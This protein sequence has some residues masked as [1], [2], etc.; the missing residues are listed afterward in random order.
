MPA[1]GDAHVDILVGGEACKE[2]P[3]DDGK[4]Y[5]EMDLQHA[6]SYDEEYVDDTPHGVEKS[7]WPV[8][9]FQVSCRN[10]S[11]HQAYWAELH[12]DGSYV[13]Q[14]L[15]EP[16]KTV[17]FQGFPRQGKVD[18][19]LMALPRNQRATD[20]DEVVGT[21]RLSSTGSVTVQFKPAAFTHTQEQYVPGK[22][23]DFRQAN[24]IEANKANKQRLAEGSKDNMTGTARQGRTIGASDDSMATA[25]H[26]RVNIWDKG[27]VREALTVHYRQRH[28][29]LNLGVWREKEAVASE[30]A[31]NA[32]LVKTKEALG[33]DWLPHAAEV[34]AAA[35]A[36]QLYQLPQPAACRT[37]TG[38]TGASILKFSRGDTPSLAVG[39]GAHARRTEQAQLEARLL[40]GQAAA[41]VT[42][43]SG[44]SSSGAGASSSGS[45]SGGGGGGSEEELWPVVV[46]GV[47]SVFSAAAL[48]LFGTEDLWFLLRLV[49][50]HDAAACPERY[51]GACAPLHQRPRTAAL[52]SSDA[53]PTL[54][55]RSACAPLTLRLRSAHAPLT[56]NPRSCR[57]LLL[58]QTGS[59]TAWASSR[60]PS[61]RTRRC[62]RSP[63][64]RAPTSCCAARPTAACRTPSAPPPSSASPRTSPRT[65]WRVCPHP[66]PPPPAAA[67]AA[68]PTGAN[69]RT[70]PCWTGRPP[71]RCAAPAPT[72]TAAGPCCATRA[73]GRATRSARASRPST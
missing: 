23:T 35:A 3:H 16:G 43:T 21:S 47:N 2:Y 62:S 68:A 73:R 64:R 34:V 63:T 55:L 36:Y 67:A 39:G 20:G 49:A 45:S 12:L 65:C 10:L 15:L 37:P 61:T 59:R 48:A 27:A 56:L 14:R 32:L 40:G 57:L 28:V 50:K 18:E 24:K 46:E 58:S 66:P 42:G 13:D 70:R 22:S 72:R 51:S 71:R 38:T 4:T 33:R 60:R 69:R 17:V 29:L 9:P 7:T 19:F 26:K 25:G 5:I 6:T 31:F 44:A 30:G 8:T 54:R 52:L 1:S 41:S 11:S 53:P